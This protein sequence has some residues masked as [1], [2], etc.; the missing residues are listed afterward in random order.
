MAMVNDKI[1]PEEK[2]LKVIKGENVPVPPKV[3]P[4]FAGS[5]AGTV[6]SVVPPLSAVLESIINAP[7][8]VR[9]GTPVLPAVPLAFDREPRGAS[10]AQTGKSLS[11]QEQQAMI[12]NLAATYSVAP[13]QPVPAQTTQAAVKPQT[14]FVPAQ[15]VVVPASPETPKP[16]PVV[17][18]VMPAKTASAAPAKA[19]VVTGPASERPVT[20]VPLPEQ[21]TVQAVPAVAKPVPVKDTVAP[22][23][24]AVPVALPVD[25]PVT[26]VTPVSGVAAPA[27]K[28]AVSPPAAEAVPAVQPKPKPVVP[29]PAAQT[30]PAAQSVSKPVNVPDSK[31][32]S[33]PVTAVPVQPVKPV[34]QAVKEQSMSA[35]SAAPLK[36]VAPPSKPVEPPK[37]QA[38][39]KAEPKPVPPQ[40]A[41]VSKV[42]AS[43]A[44]VK[45]VEVQK[46]KPAVP[47]AQAPVPAA[48]KSVEAKAQPKPEI[49]TAATVTAKPPAQPEKPKVATPAPADEKPK[50]KV[51]KSD[52]A[53]AQDAVKP[54][55]LKIKPKTVSAEEPGDMVPP[56]PVVIAKKPA[57][58][59]RY[60]IRNINL[61]LVAAILLLI[62][63]SVSEIFAKLRTDEMLN[64]I[65]G[66]LEQAVAGQN[67]QDAGVIYQLP[68]LETIVQGMGDRPLLSLPGQKVKETAIAGGPE[69][70][71]QMMD[72]MKY[73]QDSVKLMGFSG[74]QTEGTQQAIVQEGKDKDSR[75]NFFKQGQ[76]VQI[77]GRDIQVES[78]KDD[79]VVLNDGQRKMTLK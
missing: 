63:F 52:A 74:S 6:S 20:R 73:V 57:E 35:V 71:P 18:P 58:K 19:E 7:N 16:Q 34:P 39:P 21:K 31:V 67:G 47:V 61:G 55:E 78:I 60:V 65:P 75:I 22:K 43:P 69:K 2:L 14:S 79:Q 51:A 1:S 68:A 26:Q 13:R 11:F 15:P 36:A 49:K 42:P 30:A 10:S 72:W 37:P 64:Q 5:N 3:V 4:S 33:K 41:A 53:V 32:E 38:A 62:A 48:P 25:K 24:V 27:A 77:Q 76:K 45:P 59:K 54:V 12:R 9:S 56:P 46:P 17:A 28:P 8:P 70:A 50:L 23:P 40:P 66:P 44:A 29:P